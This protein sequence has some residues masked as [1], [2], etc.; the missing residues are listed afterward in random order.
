LAAVHVQ[1]Q[2]F[3]ILQ[4][5]GYED[6]TYVVVDIRPAGVRHVIDVNGGGC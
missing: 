5:R 2:L 1:G 3:W 6:E 4:E